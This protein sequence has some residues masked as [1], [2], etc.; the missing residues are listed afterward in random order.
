VRRDCGIN[1]DAC[2]SG[3]TLP[4][5]HGH[6]RTSG[7]SINVACT[8][9]SIA[10]HV[11]RRLLVDHAGAHGALERARASGS[12]SSTLTGALTLEGLD[13]IA[14]DAALARLAALDRP[15]NRL[16]ELRGYGA[17]TGDEMAR[18]LGGASITVK[19]D[20]AL[21]RAWLFGDVRGDA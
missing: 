4:P 15:H 21:A 14:L 16:V 19:R 6:K 5:A 8:S 10:A 20:W 7:S 1:E 18:V 13:V 17:R 12:P 11:M 3:L 9:L 2:R